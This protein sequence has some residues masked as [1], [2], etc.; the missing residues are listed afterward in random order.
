M[1]VLALAMDPFFQ[2]V[3]DLQE[4]W[5][6]TGNGSLNI[7][8]QYSPRDNR[9]FNLEIDNLVTVD[10]TFSLTI[11][12]FSYQNGSQPVLFGNVS[13]P[14]I[15]IS[16][17][18]RNCTWD[19]YDTLG[20]CSK[21]SDI[22]R[23][24]TFGC[25]TT[26]VDWTKGLVGEYDSVR[27]H[28]SSIPFPKG[29]SCGYFLNGTSQKPVLM[30]GYLLDSSNV[31]LAQPGEVLL[32][33]TMNMVSSPMKETIYGG[34]INFKHVRNPL[35]NFI[36]SGAADGTTASVYRN[37]TPACHEC[38][39]HWCVKRIR[40]SYYQGEYREQVVQTFHN[41][42]ASTYLWNVVTNFSL[43]RTQQKVTIDYLQNVTIEVP[44]SPTS[45]NFS[46]TNITHFRAFHSFDNIFP[47]FY[48]QSNNSDIRLLRHSNYHQRSPTRDTHENP[49][50]PPANVTNHVA[51]LAL[52]LSNGLRGHSTSQALVG[53]G[54]DIERYVHVE[55]AWLVFP[56]LI[57]CMS[58]VFLIATIWKTQ[59]QEDGIGVWKSSAMATLV[60]GGVSEDL[61]Q[62]IRNSRSI[63]TPRT[64]ARTM[65][66]RLLPNKGWRLSVKKPR[67]T[68]SSQLDQV[69]LQ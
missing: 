69:P 58:L 5:T 40:S 43:P 33:R 7:L 17:P 45:K 24:L 34:S 50:I 14:E 1:T 9:I 68:S 25:H 20:V 59:K 48:T 64:R 66:A 29:N 53:T 32:M 57:L 63:G 35:S 61:R 12:K 54:Y 2:Q 42:T 30:S 60:Y 31:S 39:L 10:S 22:S 65:K 49:W 8:T 46:L 15:P 19:E 27:T 23:L 38:V 36:V 18:S 28:W 52:A 6:V 4:R 51:R 67:R 11:P 44:D 3:S 47:S 41:T 16:C 13:R 37:E 62:H 55:W 56:I 26:E 21:C